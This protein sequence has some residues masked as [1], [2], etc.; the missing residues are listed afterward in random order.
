MLYP[1]QQLSASGGTAPYQW[2]IASGSLPPGLNL[3]AS[4]LISGT[5]TAAPGH[6][7]LHRACHRCRELLRD[8]RFEHHR[9]LRRHHNVASLA[10]EWHAVCR[11]QPKY[12][13][14]RRHR[15]LH[16]ERGLRSAARWPHLEQWRCHQRRAARSRQRHGGSS[17]HGCGWLRQGAALHAH[18][19]LPADHHHAEHADECRA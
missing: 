1:D 17:R 9:R 11:L 15:A 4:G 12:V 7:Q 19:G 8:K 10:A 18:G 2:T 16:L 13:R 6:L 14:E 5:I 3:S